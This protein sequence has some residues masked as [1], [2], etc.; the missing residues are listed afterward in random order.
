MKLALLV[1]TDGRRACL[2]TTL[3]SAVVNLPHPSVAVMVN[4]EPNEEWCLWLDSTFGDD[5]QILHPRSGRR[6]FAGA[7]QAGWDALS[8]LDCTHVFHLEDDFT[9][10]L[11][12]P[13]EAMAEVLDARPHLVQL[14]LRRQPWNE[15]ERA[16]GGIV[17]LHPH[18]FVE[19]SDGRSAWLEHRRFFTTN[20]S[21]Y[22]RSL[23]DRG[24]PQGP[25]SEGRFGIR[26]CED[27]GVRFGYWGARDS[28]EWVTHIGDHRAGSGY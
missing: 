4:D 23:I 17:E 25:E 21:L 7:I 16:A 5:F 27:P 12:V 18:D 9:F 3:A 24:W 28:G 10:N 13:I 14:A 20:P 11:P 19:V 1:L 8:D 22:R 26:L 15:A 6:G 2:E